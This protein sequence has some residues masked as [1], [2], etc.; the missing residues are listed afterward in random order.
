M[1]PFGASDADNEQQNLSAPTNGSRPHPEKLPL[2]PLKSSRG[3]PN[4]GATSVQMTDKNPRPSRR[5]RRRRRRRNKRRRQRTQR[6]KMSP[7]LQLPP[8]RTLEPPETG[9]LTRPR[10]DPKHISTSWAS[11]SRA[12]NPPPLRDLRGQVLRN[13]LGSI[14]CH[15][16][17]H[18]MWKNMKDRLANV[19]N[20]KRA[21]TPRVDY[22]RE[23][24]YA[25]WRFWWRRPPTRPSTIRI[26]GPANQAYV[27]GEKKVELDVHRLAIMNAKSNESV[28]RIKS[29][30]FL[31]IFHL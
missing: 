8:Y 26:L 13:G 12:A 23:Q 9:V 24:L 3:L 30:S 21:Y 16:A 29:Y 1:A 17:H 4:P 6:R 15:P 5:E 22:T 14:I 19:R 31:T 18:K 2:T 20:G 10:F 28:Q 25:E 27:K 11:E 7:L